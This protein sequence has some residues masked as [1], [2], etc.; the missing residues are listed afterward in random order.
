MNRERIT[1]ID[2]YSIKRQKKCIYKIDAY[3]H[4]TLRE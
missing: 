4:E 1:S 3:K 2:N